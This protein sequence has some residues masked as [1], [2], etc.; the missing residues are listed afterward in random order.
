MSESVFEHRFRSAL[1]GFNREDVV[2]YIEAST[3]EYEDEIQQ[4][5]GTNNRLNEQLAEASAQIEQMKEWADAAREL[6]AARS[7]LE[8]LQRENQDLHAQVA[9]L[10]EQLEN[11]AVAN[12]QPQKEAIPIQP[13]LS[14]PII[15]VQAVVPEEL[16]PAKDYAELELAAYR[17]A[18]IAE[19]LA[20]ERARD[21]YRKVQSVF[22]SASGKLD[23]S[24]ADLDQL[25]QTI[26]ENVSQLLLLLSGIRSSYEDTQA[27]FAAVG[28]CNRKDAEL[29]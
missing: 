9:E 23:T 7:R 27:A 13:D 11:V 6:E 26:R 3:R 1:H 4:L 28:D 21:V 25:T 5:R 18:E 24:K 15:P 17:R 29:I 10:E 22:G 20:K 2:A 12:H 14:E 8:A 19:R 16:S